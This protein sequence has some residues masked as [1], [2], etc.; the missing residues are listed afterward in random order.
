[1]IRF[2]V[3]DTYQVS[4]DVIGNMERKRIAPKGYL[5]ECDDWFYTFALI[6][7]AGIFQ[8]TIGD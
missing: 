1:M 2:C 8:F 6:D 7:E 5:L 4:V 3:G